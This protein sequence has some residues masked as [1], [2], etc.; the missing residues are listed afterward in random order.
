MLT[1]SI[2][3][4][5]PP[6]C[7]DIEPMCDVFEPCSYLL[8]LLLLLSILRWPIMY[9]AWTRLISDGQLEI[10]QDFVDTSNR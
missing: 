2:T 5:K 9:F 3:S 8:L 6:L 10:I 4:V 1:G 7:Q